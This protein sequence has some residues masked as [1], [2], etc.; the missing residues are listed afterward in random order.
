MLRKTLL[1]C[2]ILAAVIYVSR[3][4]A[5]WSSYPGYDF[6]N[7]V[8]SELSAIDVP[9]RGIDVTVGR[10]YGLFTLLF[11]AG[12]WLSARTGALRTAAVLLAGATIFGAFWPP[13]HMRGVPAGPSDT[14]HI[15]WTAGWLL[16]TL[17]AMGLAGAA[18]GRRF[19]FYTICAAGLMLVFGALTGWQGAR[20]AANLPTPGIGIF[21]RASIGAFLLWTVVLAV[22]LWPARFDRSSA[23]IA[24]RAA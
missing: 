8:I 2:G 6:P 18:L 13:M 24:A 10:A 7:Q 9:S 3:D 4:L 16:L 19:L 20:L 12:V 21:E 22:D 11:S 23:S 17:A 14:L 15:V 5:A 1:C